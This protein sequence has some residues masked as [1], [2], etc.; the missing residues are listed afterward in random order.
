MD[1]YA[2][3][4]KSRPDQQGHMPVWMEQ[5]QRKESQGEAETEQSAASVRGA[6]WEDGPLKEGLPELMKGNVS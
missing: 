5:K 2:K 6:L 1:A 4:K 3:R